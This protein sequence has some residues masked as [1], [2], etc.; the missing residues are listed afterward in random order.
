MNASTVLGYSTS[1]VPNRDNSAARSSTNPSARWSSPGLPERLSNGASAIASVAIMCCP[2]GVSHCEGRPHAFRVRNRRETVPYI[3]FIMF[4]GRIRRR[5]RYLAPLALI[6]YLGAHPVAGQTLADAPQA[7]ELAGLGTLEYRVTTSAVQ[8]Q[9]FF[10]QGL[11]L[12]YAFNHAEALRAFREAAHQDPRLA[13]AYWGQAVTLGRNLNA[14]MSAEN[15]QEAYEAVQRAMAA[16]GSA[17]E[18]ERRLIAALSR[19]YAADAGGDRRALDRDYA[20]AMSQLAQQYPDD[21]EIQT[22]FA[23]AVMNTMPWDYWEK[24][25]APKRDIAPVIA[26]LERIIAREPNHPG[27]NHY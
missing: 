20:A 4:S 5:V 11:R 3:N 17:S 7:P 23:D 10:N 9:R 26:A 15:G 24:N 16:A 12:L 8:A 14:P 22:L 6:G 25:G 21:P 1:S 27:A 19:R 2:H 18:R 13:M